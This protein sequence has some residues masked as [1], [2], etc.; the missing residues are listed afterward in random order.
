MTTEN[1]ADGTDRAITTDDFGT[2]HRGERLNTM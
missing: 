2:Q 1:G